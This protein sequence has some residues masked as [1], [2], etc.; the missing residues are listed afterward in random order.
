MNSALPA[1]PPPGGQSLL[2]RARSEAIEQF[3]A[4]DRVRTR[5]L[6]AANDQFQR[7]GIHR[8][9]MEDVAR[10]AGVSRITVYRRFATKEELVEQVILRE[11]GLYFT[12]FLVD[13][14]AA[15]NVG[16][17][18]V[19]G[20]VSSLGALRGNPMIHALI[21]A[22]PDRSISTLIGDSSRATAIV[23]EFVASQLLSEQ[24]AG[25]VATEL[26]VELV[27]EMMVRI[28]ASFLAIPSQ[29]VDLD[30][31]DELA[32]VARQFL[33]PMLDPPAGARGRDQPS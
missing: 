14:A 3:S 8:S 21:T 17:R 6:D 24:R 30:N 7:L 31:D 27:A 15:P 5:I 10:Q 11:L 32:D 13:I 19:R 29:V 12:R 9:T 1:N 28:C 22:E 26:R 20:F 18:V 4:T 33:V 23:R 2:E 16:E 25:N